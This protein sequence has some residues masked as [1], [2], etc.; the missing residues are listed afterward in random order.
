MSRSEHRNGWRLLRAL[1]AEHRGLFWA[2]VLFSTF[3]NILM[4]TGPLYMLQVY[5]RVLSSRSEATLVAL[6]ALTAF[7]F[8][9]L[10][11]I[12]HARARILAR[13]GAR[14][15]DRLDS[16]VFNGALRR[17]IDD[18]GDSVARSAQRDVEAVRALWV[19]PVM[20][21][22]MD[23][24]W[25]PF[26]LALIFV[27]HPL[28][29][30]LAFAGGI[31][32][33]AIAF[34]NQ[35]N[36][37]EHIALAAAASLNADRLAELVKA[38][39]ETIR[40]LG[41]TQ[42]A[43]QRWQ[44][45]RSNAL[46]ETIAAS[47]LGGAYAAISRTF[48]L[49][50]QSAMLG[51]GAWV[52]LRGELSPGAM[53]AGSILLGRALLPV[54]QAIGQWAVV[55]RAWDARSRLA[56]LLSHVAM[57]EQR[58]TLPRPKAEIDVA[59]LTLIPPG[60][61]QPILRS[62]SFTLAPGQALGLIGPSGAGKSS[63]ARALTGLWRPAAGTIRLDGATLDQYDLDVL[64][65]Y[66]GYLPQRVSLFE[67]T[68]AENIARLGAPDDALLIAAAS[69]ANAHDMILGLPDG[70]DTQVASIGSRLSGGQIQRIG[71][72]RALYGD[73]VL[74][75]LDEPNSSLDHEG[76]LA[77]NSAIRAHKAAGG[78]VL[79]MAHRPAVIQECDMLL[80]IEVG[81][82]RAYGPRDQ[83]LR[84]MVR[85]ANMITRTATLGGVS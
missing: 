84:E 38:E 57:D 20:V 79:V 61:T 85:N 15:Q 10:G 11:L 48:R 78:A 35:R 74:L 45:A 30:W 13:I 69:A 42:A 75:I 4:L 77:V 12:D 55:S 67:G 60:E 34:L 24:P 8:L 29:G 47:D 62:L 64:G 39:C 44:T 26:Y 71:L 25:T 66:F 73:P 33:V 19:S 54:E 36:T 50:L 83:I 59:N 7:L 56:A 28:L 1:G 81:A 52:V 43:Y 32:I 2:V 53:I 40:A 46:T 70:Y 27:F 58:T 16:Y 22:L 41:M 3:V 18:P 76:S 9:T 72:A 49:F 23:L 80:V 21:A 51:L 65:R 14:Q 31:V 17:L 6:S 82:R 68:I 63:V 5:D 37:R